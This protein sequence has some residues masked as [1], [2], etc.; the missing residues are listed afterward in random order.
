LN[1][2]SA[3]GGQFSSTSSSFDAE[4]ESESDDETHDG[5]PYDEGELLDG[6][7]DELNVYDLDGVREKSVDGV[8]LVD[9]VNSE[10][11]SCY[12]K[13]RIEGKEKFL[14]KQTACWLLTEEKHS[15]SADRV[16]RVMQKLDG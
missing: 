8:R 15:L 1:L 12:F 14:H 10:T 9:R 3:R 11:A 6:S 2:T 7:D 16:M 13:V 4:S 5:G